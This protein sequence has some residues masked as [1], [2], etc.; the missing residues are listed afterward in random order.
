MKWMKNNY[1]NAK[2][3][4]SSLSYGPSGL[5][6]CASW[7]GTVSI[8]SQ[9]ERLAEVTFSR[10]VLSVAWMQP[11]A[12]LLV[13]GGENRVSKINLHQQMCEDILESSGLP[14]LDVKPVSS[15][16]FTAVSRHGLH[17]HDLRVANPISAPNISSNTSG[18]TQIDT[19]DSQLVVINEN[20]SRVFDY[21]KLTDWVSEYKLGLGPVPLRTVWLNRNQYAVSDSASQISVVNIN[22]CEETY[23]FKSNRVDAKP[24]PIY[25]L[26]R[27]NTTTVACGGADCNVYIWDYIKRSLVSKSMF[28]LACTALSYSATGDVAVGLSTDQWR[29][30]HYKFTEESKSKVM[31]ALA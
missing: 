15:C 3:T 8:V 27:G 11:T 19:Q 7:D 20:S 9:L 1:I 13:C 26:A 30:T 5:L 25:S 6:A 4:V 31:V 17:L 2:D 28:P 21:R 18:G 10:P 22:D 12:E 29:N 23:V 16:L 24:R 14:F